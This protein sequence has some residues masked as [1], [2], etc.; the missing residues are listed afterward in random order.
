MLHRENPSLVGSA[1][2]PPLRFRKSFLQRTLF[3]TVTHAVPVHLQAT[4]RVRDLSPCWRRPLE[5]ASSHH[6]SC[7]TSCTAGSP[8]AEATRRSSSN[9]LARAS[10]AAT[11]MMPL[12]RETK[13]ARRAERTAACALAARGCA[14]SRKKAVPDSKLGAVPKWQAFANYLDPPR[15]GYRDREIHVG[16]DVAGD[17]WQLLEPGDGSL[18]RK[19]EGS[20]GAGVGT[21]CSMVAERVKQP[22]ACTDSRGRVAA[23]SGGGG[24]K[25]PE[26]L[27]RGC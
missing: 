22:T 15:I 13:A 9:E 4:W 3:A 25:A 8:V 10:C 6:S 16:K 19:G 17:S 18:E 21:C 27:R 20:Q 14:R 23:A 1:L 26:T 11:A 2:A 7:R 12:Q 5:A 24:A